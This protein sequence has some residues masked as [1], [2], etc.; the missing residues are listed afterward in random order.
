M[1]NIIE[2]EKQWMRYKI[3]SYLPH[4]T[5][6]MS[7]LI[8]TLVSFLFLDTKQQRVPVPEK[9]TSLP[10]VKK[11]LPLAKAKTQVKT[12]EKP[13]EKQ[14]KLQPSLNFEYA[15]QNT[16]YSPQKVVK[17]EKTQVKEVPKKAPKILVKESVKI[18]IQK[19]DAKQDFQ[20]IIQRFQNSNDP[21]LSL[22]IAKKYYEQKNYQ[23]AYNYA[24]AT[25]KIDNKID[26]SWIVFCKALVHLGKKKFAIKVLKDYIH[27]SQ[28]TAASILLS[29]IQSGKFR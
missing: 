27:A 18:H 28:S 4:F 1:L 7:L 16:Q 14:L 19:K 20:K 17:K 12:Q 9:N 24:L 6:L 29:D 11:V 2:L 23:E 8:I 5:I 13:K 10:A 22:F 26:E 3:K 15:L 21:H 25:N